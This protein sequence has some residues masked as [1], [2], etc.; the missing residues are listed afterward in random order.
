M[1]VEYL[2]AESVNERIWIRQFDV[3]SDLSETQPQNH[4]A[5]DSFFFWRPSCWRGPECVSQS[6]PR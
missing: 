3:S 2:D 6:P 5:F 4:S 1:T